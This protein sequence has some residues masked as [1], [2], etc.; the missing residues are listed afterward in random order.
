MS[1]HDAN[2]DGATRPVISKPTLGWFKAS[3]H[4][5]AL[6]L[7]RANPFA[8]VLAAIIAH[9]A[10]WRDGFNPNKLRMGEALLGDH[11]NYGMTMQRYRTA[12]KYLEDWGFA[13]IRAT[14]RGTVAKLIDTRLFS[15]LPG[16]INNQINEPSTITATTAATTNQEHKTVRTKTLVGLC[17]PQASNTPRSPIAFEIPT[18]KQLLEYCEEMGHDQEIALQWADGLA[19]KGWTIRGQRIRYWR[20]VLDRFLEKVECDKEQFPF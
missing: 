8:Y 15:I 7:I 1:K 10:K 17:S 18:S 11:E 20:Q 5:D 13:T 19:S 12:K 6:A 14:S 4:P 2:V 16:D 9:R 3:R